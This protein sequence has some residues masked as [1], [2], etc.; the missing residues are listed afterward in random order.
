[1]VTYTTV[2]RDGAEV[3]LFVWQED[4]EAYVRSDPTLTLGQT[5]SCWIDVAD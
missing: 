3:A 5:F 1:M 4:A 2:L